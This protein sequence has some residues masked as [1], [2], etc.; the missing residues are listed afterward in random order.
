MNTV[1]LYTTLSYHFLNNIIS[2]LKYKRKPKYSFFIIKF[3]NNTS[4]IVLYKNAYKIKNSIS[5][6]NMYT[7]NK[8]QKDDIVY[9]LDDWSNCLN[10]TIPIWDFKQLYNFV[11]ACKKRR[12]DNYLYE[13]SLI[14]NKKDIK[15]ILRGKYENFRI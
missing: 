8:I 9:D 14:V 4:E 6:Y 3:R 7:F 2:Y 12:D 15:K 5:C 11:K 10:K 1:I 13:Y